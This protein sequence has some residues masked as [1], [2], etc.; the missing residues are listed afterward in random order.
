MT[1]RTTPGTYRDGYIDKHI[2]ALVLVFIV[3]FLTLPARAIDISNTPLDVTYKTAAPAVMIVLDDSGSMDWEFMTPEEHGTFHTTDSSSNIIQNIYL[4]ADP[5]DDQYLPKYHRLNDEDRRLWKSQWS[6]YNTLFYTPQTLYSPWPNPSGSGN[7]DNASTTAPRSNPMV[8]TY[9]LTLADTYTQV[10]VSGQTVDIHN[11]HYYLVNDINMNGLA[12]AGE[13][14]FLINFFGQNR[15]CYR[16][17]DTNDNGRIENDELETVSMDQIPATI[18]PTRDEGEDLQNF[19]NWYSYYRR[20]SLCTKAA[21]ARTI[22]ELSAIRIG[23]YSIN[24]N[25]ITSLLPLKLT[26][27]SGTLEDSTET[28]LTQ[29]YSLTCDGGTPLREGLNA[30][31]KYYKGDNPDSLGPSPF[32]TSENG[33]ECQRV[34]AL[35][36]TDGYWTETD[37]SMSSPDPDH[38]GV[39]NTL[40]DVAMTYYQADLRNDLDDRLSPT[41]CDPAEY[42]HMVTFAVSFG[43]H[44][45]IDPN[46]YDPCTLENA[47]GQSPDW[48]T[49]Y[50]ADCQA[51]ID[52]LWHATINSKG[53]F[54]NASDPDSLIFSLKNIFLSI[55]NREAT[56][57]SVSVSMEKFYYGDTMYQGSYNSKNW[58]GDLQAYAI[59]YDDTSQTTSIDPTPLWGASDKLQNLSW[60]ERTII[61]YN[62][63]TGIAFRWDSLSDSQ[64]SMLTDNEDLLMFL[65]GKDDENFRNRTAVLGD[66]VHSS[67]LLVGKHLYIGANDGM[68][69][70]FN[71]TDGTETFAYVPNLIFQ[72]LKFLADT[73]YEHRYFVDQT[74]VCSDIMVG[75]DK[76]TLLVGGLGKGGKGYYCLDIT[77]METRSDFSEQALK[78][79]VQWEF[80]DN[81]NLGY[82]LSS[83]IIV[84]TYS[85]THPVVVIFGNG[86][87]STSERSQLFIVDIF[88]GIPVKIIDTEVGNDNGMSTPIATDVNNDSKVDYVYAG[89]LNGNLWKFDL[90]SDNDAAWSVSFLD[91]DDHPAPL[92]KTSPGQAITT[93]PDVMRH[94]CMHGYMVCFGTGKHLGLSD[95]SAPSQQAIYGI[96]DYGDDPGESLGELIPATKGLTLHPDSNT[97]E[98][99]L[100]EQTITDNYS[101]GQCLFRRISKNFAEWTTV[102]DCTDTNPN[103]RIRDCRNNQPNPSRHIGWTLK[104]PANERVDQDVH[105]RNNV[106]TVLGKNPSTAPCEGGGYS[107]VYAL[108]PCSGYM[109]KEAQTTPEPK[110]LNPPVT[111]TTPDGEMLIYDKDSPPLPPPFDGVKPGLYFWR[112][113]F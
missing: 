7:L 1:Q 72:D 91:Q 73:H 8:A 12:D 77:G 47:Q 50:C 75:K 60:D 33:G 90:T 66:I 49:P 35:V 105:I 111:I 39:E 43:V 92:F 81:D 46:E 2:M 62:G 84:R 37:F 109:I 89:D 101:V 63:Q 16:V 38:D 42:Q 113:L 88:T 23:F 98:V 74:P 78:D 54:F 19:A 53:A 11:S 80:S 110:I 20:R 52:D 51:K 100:L 70:V 61:S 83:P 21:V 87:N 24:T 34:Y 65:R 82:T 36:M 94:C 93:R 86:Y 71:S 95:L 67:P 59:T 48:I 15:T 9:T 41:D 106:L 17:N 85:A 13:E 26:N 107:M 76:K 29:L 22:S 27:S 18:R 44:G 45:T 99:R 102:S 64:K 57:A 32:E 108:N 5:G 30:V 69:H 40:A 68:M 104:L 10:L 97:S 28:L 3:L 14:I 112:E 96:W 58:T 55:E 31:G 103:Q 25:L 79:M 4:F 56:G 6:G